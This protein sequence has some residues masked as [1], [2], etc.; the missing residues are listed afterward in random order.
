MSLADFHCEVFDISIRFRLED[1]DREAFAKDVEAEENHPPYHR[2]SFGSTEKPG[3]EHAHI[4]VEFPE[5][6]ESGDE[7]PGKLRIVFH[8]S[9][10]DVEDVRP[11]YM[12]DCAIWIGR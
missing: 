7:P 4:T 8:S 11:P 3:T 10:E 6:N 2:W 12:E 1:F 5:G 9:E